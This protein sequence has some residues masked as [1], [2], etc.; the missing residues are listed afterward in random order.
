MWML[1]VLACSDADSHV[2]LASGDYA[3]RTEAAV[4][5]C[6]GGA[7]EA[8]FMP[9][10]P[11]T[12]HAFTYPIRIPGPNE[13]PATYDIDLREPFVGMPV[14][15]EDAG[16]GAL[17]VRGAVMESVLLDE[18]RYGD[19]AATM[20]VDIDLTPLTSTTLRGQARLQVSDARG[21]EELCPVFAADPCL[22]TL[23]VAASRQ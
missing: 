22:V 18:V 14:T 7:L 21:E 10:G 1:L 12:P 19:C 15:V 23:A 8:L 2:T 17:A 5:E 3:F 6:L 11:D 4:D 13:L 20:T 16:Q 9:E